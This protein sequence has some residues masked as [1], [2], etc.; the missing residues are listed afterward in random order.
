MRPELTHD[1]ELCNEWVDMCEEGN[2]TLEAHDLGDG[3]ISIHLS[4]KG[5]NLGDWYHRDEAP[6]C[7]E[8]GANLYIEY[9]WH[10]TDPWAWFLMGEAV[11]A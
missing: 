6:N 4:H 1:G 11:H 5:D 2:V 7:P 8:C 10:D 3:R 9:G